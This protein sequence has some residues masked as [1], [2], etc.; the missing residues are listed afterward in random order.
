[1]VRGE[2]LV[3]ELEK[4]WRGGGVAYLSGEGRVRPRDVNLWQPS[5][6]KPANPRCYTARRFAGVLGIGDGQERMASP[7]A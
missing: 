4:S 2:N 6:Q 3:G 1:M 7:A 5:S